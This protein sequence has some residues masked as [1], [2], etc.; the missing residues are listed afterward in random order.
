MPALTWETRWFFPGTPPDG[1]ARALFG[2]G[3]GPGAPDWSTPRT[4]RYL[5][6]SAQMG[7]KLRD[8]PGSPVL[9]EFKGRLATPAPIRFGDGVAGLGDSWAKWSLPSDGVPDELLAAV[10]S[11]R[12]V[13]PVTKT[14]LLT[15]LELLDGGQDR[16]VP[17]ETRVERG[18]QLELSRVQVG[19]TRAWSV[20]VEAFPMDAE[21][22]D[23]V[24][25]SVTPWLQAAARAGAPLDRAHA[26]AYPAWLL[27]QERNRGWR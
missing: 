5:V 8:E 3:A 10:R 19:E 23:R 15:V 6:F 25:P 1:M 17:P 26:A 16:P 13:V 22:A 14:R 27:A 12:R 9:L 24:R 21:L 11:G 2:A 20:G 7:I 4:D 18:V